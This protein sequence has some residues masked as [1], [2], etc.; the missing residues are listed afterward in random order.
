MALRCA[1]AAGKWSSPGIS[2]LTPI[3]AQQ[4]GWLLFYPCLVF[5]KAIPVSPERERGGLR[6]RAVGSSSSGPMW[7]APALHLVAACGTGVC[8]GGRGFPWTEKGL[9]WALR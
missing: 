3:P 4:E 5:P 6:V 1:G 8:G 9:G 2:C 7:P